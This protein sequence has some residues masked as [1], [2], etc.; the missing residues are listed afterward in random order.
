VV[1]S[2][3]EA[4]EEANAT[5]GTERRLPSN[6]SVS[7][8]KPPLGVLKINWDAALQQETKNMGVGVVIRDDSGAFVAA[9]S[10]IVP[11]IVDPLTAET[12]AVWHAAQLV[13]E[14]GYQHV[15]LERDSLSVISA[16]KKEGHC[17]IGC[18]QLI[19]YTKL[20]LSRLAN[21]SFQHVKKDANKAA[22]CMA[23]FAL[24]QLLDKVWVE[25]Y[26]LII[27][28]IVLAEQAEDY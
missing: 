19:S 15:L 18:G 5:I 21:H 22:H 24:S 23:K 2:S 17:G 8:K 11:Y 13:C 9:I 25:D 4:F 20:I 12:V 6:G 10:K 27:Q 1:K 26:P 14:M 28:H 3:L 7:R 16:L